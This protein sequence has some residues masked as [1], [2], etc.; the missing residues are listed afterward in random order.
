MSANWFLHTWSLLQNDSIAELILA[1]RQVR[2][3]R[4]HNVLHFVSVGRLWRVTLVHVK[5]CIPY[6]IFQWIKIR[7]IW[8]ILVLSNYSN[9]KTTAPGA[10]T[11]RDSREEK[12]MGGK[13]KVSWGVIGANFLR[14]VTNKCKRHPLQLILSSTTNRVLRETTLLPFTSAFFSDIITP[15]LCP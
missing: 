9:K 7:W 1:L 15:V 5:H 3:D 2:S 11:G 12:G 10:R 13:Y 8:R 14:L 4:L 6:V